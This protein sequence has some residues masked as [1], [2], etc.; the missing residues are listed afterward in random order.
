[1]I[2]RKAEQGDEKRQARRQVGEDRTEAGEGP[3]E[4]DEVAPTVR[5]LEAPRTDAAVEAGRREKQQRQRAVRQ[6]P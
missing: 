5:A 4:G 2:E 1:M 6:E 3:A